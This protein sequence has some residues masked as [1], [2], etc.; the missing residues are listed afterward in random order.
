MLRDIIEKTLFYRD[1]DKTFFETEEFPWVARIEAG[2]KLIRNELDALMARRDEIPNFQDV[3]KAQG[4]LTE[5]NQWK[6]FLLFHFWRQEN[7]RELRAM[8]ETVRLLQRHFG[9]EDSPCF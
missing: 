5:G 1:G 4:A 3:S 8:P 7:R 2:W 9:A 6:T